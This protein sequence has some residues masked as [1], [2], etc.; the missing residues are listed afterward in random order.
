MQ[1]YETLELYVT[2]DSY[3]KKH[4]QMCGKPASDEQIIQAEKQ[5]NIQMNEE[6]KRFIKRYGGCFIG[7]EVVAFDNASMLGKANVIEMTEG[8]RT[9]VMDEVD[10]DYMTYLAIGDDGS[11]NNFVMS[12]GSDNIFLFDHDSGELELIAESFTD[13]VDNFLPLM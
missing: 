11:G 12:Y 3:F 2:L 6:Y 9:L 7:I 13:L 4:A 5:L 8:F 1:L 10:F